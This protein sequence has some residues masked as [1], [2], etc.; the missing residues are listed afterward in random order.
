MPEKVIDSA[1]GGEYFCHAD[2]TSAGL[3]S[4]KNFM[5]TYQIEWHWFNAS[6]GGATLDINIP[7]ALVG[8]QVSFYGISGGGLHRA[9]IKHY[10]KRL[11]SGQ[12]EEHDFGEWP[13]WPPVIVDHI[14]SVTL[15]VGL[16]ER[17][18]G[19]LVARMDYWE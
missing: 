9:G 17:Q 18:E 3:D 6:N 19:S 5:A 14:S 4:K 8:V 1:V 2:C 10:R 12:D 16:G 15:A 11:D 7:P 13:S